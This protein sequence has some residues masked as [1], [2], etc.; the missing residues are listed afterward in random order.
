[1]SLSLHRG[2]I[3]GVDNILKI[4]ASEEAVEARLSPTVPRAARS[5]QCLYCRAL[6]RSV[7]QCLYLILSQGTSH[8]QIGTSSCLSRDQDRVS[9]RDLALQLPGRVRSALVGDSFDREPASL[10][11]LALLKTKSRCCNGPRVC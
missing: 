9:L 8:P 10:L 6:R 7:A 11:V 5:K 4:I 2:R 3:Y 1:M